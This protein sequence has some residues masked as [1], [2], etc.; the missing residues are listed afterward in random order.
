MQ[1]SIAVAPI[2]LSTAPLPLTAAAAAGTNAAIRIAEG[3]TTIKDGYFTVGTDASGIANSCILVATAR[4]SQK[5]HLKIYGGVFE[6]KGNPIN[7]WY[8]VINIQDADRKAGR[9]TVEIYGGIFINY[10]PATGDN[11][12]EADDTFVAP[13][14]KS[15]ETTYNGQQAWQV[16]PE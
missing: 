10:N 2:W 15:V 13:G 14:Y 3:T 12:G 9:A 7:G 4:P 11:T 6:T 8:P 16:I 5:A 1:A